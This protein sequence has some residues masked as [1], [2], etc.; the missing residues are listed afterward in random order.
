MNCRIEGCS[1]GIKARLMC[2]YHYQKARRAG[3]F[4]L[5]W[6]IN[7]EQPKYIT[8]HKRLERT[9]GKATAHLCV[10]C[11]KQASEWSYNNDP[12]GAL[13]NEWRGRNSLYSTDLSRYN[14]RCLSCHRQRDWDRKRATTDGPITYRKAA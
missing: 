6:V 7:K 5:Y 14:P 12:E 4:E 11:S 8:V 3:E 2:E 13:V 10:D 9:R 1:K